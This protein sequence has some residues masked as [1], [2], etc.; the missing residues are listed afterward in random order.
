[1]LV[2]ELKK[3]KTDDPET[4]ELIERLLEKLRKHYRC[5]ISFTFDATVVRSD[6]GAEDVVVLYNDAH[7]RA[8]AK[9]HAI[10]EAES[11]EE[12]KRRC[13][14]LIDIPEDCGSCSILSPL[15][16][17]ESIEVEEV[18]PVESD[19]APDGAI[20]PFCGTEINMD[21]P[22]CRH[23]VDWTRLG[24]RVVVYFREVEE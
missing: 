11:E 14:A 16:D 6:L 21:A 24:D 2:E 10:V 1:M 8:H 15:L 18:V 7:V 13:E 23:F 22:T 4:K 19:S 12:A 17:I 3:F 5:V 20:C 9:V